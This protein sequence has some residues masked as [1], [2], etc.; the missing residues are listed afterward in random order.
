MKSIK[1]TILFLLVFCSFTEAFS[2]TKIILNGRVIDKSDKSSIIGATIIESDKDNRVVNGSITDVNG[3]FILQMK[4]SQ[5]TVAVSYIGYKLQSIPVSNNKIIIE[6]EPTAIDISEVV[7]TAHARSNN[8]LTYIDDRDV[9]S[10]TV[11]IDLSEMQDLGITS[12]ADALQGKISGLDIISGSG[13]PGSG[14]Q[15]VIRGLSSM[16]NNKPLIVIDGIPQQ[17]VAEGFDLSSAEAEDISNLINIALQDIKTIEVLKDA[18]S[19]AIYGSRGSDGVLLIETYRGRMGKVQFGYQFKNSVNFQPPSIPMLNG[20]EYSILQ[21]EEW[22]NA[23]G[24]FALPPEIAYDRDF[25]DFYNYSANTDWLGLIT[26]NSITNDHYFKIN[27]GG[28]KTRYFTS[29]SYVDE[30]GTTI[31][32]GSKRFSTRV[33]LDYFLSRK[34]LFSVQFNYTSNNTQGNVSLG[35]RNIRAMAYIKAPNMSVWEYD[36]DG[37]LTGDYFTPINSYQGNGT[38]YYNPYAMAELGNQKRLRNSLENTFKAK[39]NITSWL[40]FRETVAFQYAG[41]KTNDFIPY[42]A[43]G[44]DWLN[45]NVNYAKEVNGINS[46]IKTETQLAFTAPFRNKKHELS[47]AINWITNKTSNESMQVES[48]KSPTTDIRD[49]SINPQIN[50]I[51]NWGG[52][53]RE[54]G[55]LINLNYKFKDRYMVQGILRNDAASSFGPANKWGLF[56]GLSLGW[57]FSEESFFKSFKWLNES[58]LRTSWGVSGSQPGDA[59]ARF[60]TYASTYTGSYIFSPAIVPTQIQLNKLKWETVTSYD[61]GIELNLFDNRVFIVGD[62]YQKITSDIL[63]KNYD[64]PL[65]SGFTSLKYLNGGELENRGWELM[66]DFK[67]LKKNSF[68]WSINFNASQNINSF[69][70]LPDNFNTEQDLSIGN[71]QYPK[72][73]VPGEPIGSFFGFRYLGVWASDEDVVARDGAG[74]ILHDANGVPIP[75]TYAGTYVFRGGDAKYQDVNYDGKIDLNDVVYIGDSNPEFIGGF[76]TI[77]RYRDFNF[78]AS[79]NYRLKFDI[80]NRVAINT[81]GMNDKNNQSKAVLYRWRVQGQNEPGMIPRAYLNHP[82]NNLGSDRYVEAGDFLRFNNV[83]LG[84]RIPT[85][86][87]TRFGLENAEVSVSGRKLFTITKYTGQDPEVGQDASDPFWIGEDKANT[88][89]SKIITFSISIGF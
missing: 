28:E 69:N 9:A 54:L 12:A 11:K 61:L 32:T 2:Q 53:G 74:N 23:R 76:G 88:P 27:G 87:C 10:S 56:K 21:L 13:D 36:A 43:I 18:A 57:R 81:Q 58:M 37:N 25:T 55:A 17:K 82:A 22:H 47:G 50:Y 86:I 38:S 44:I 40:I 14:S 83:K 24:V 79:F 84:Y 42:T 29:F 72:Q 49:P 77:F 1:K 6:L 39:Y 64:I 16:G 52:E 34:F 68:L 33:N 70:K 46:S 48:S 8:K 19:S 67:I 7:V 85:K 75:V 66:T 62:I 26:Q 3:N 45:Q 15:I 20:D 5:N 31:N 59:Y 51:G 4:N 65:S 89:P 73:V 30:G 71:G 41:S 78:S 63:F 80:V 60:A 35:G